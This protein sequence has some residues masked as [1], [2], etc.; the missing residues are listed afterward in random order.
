MQLSQI[1]SWNQIKS[2]PIKSYQILKSNIILKEN[3]S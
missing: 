1:K 2:Y 3:E